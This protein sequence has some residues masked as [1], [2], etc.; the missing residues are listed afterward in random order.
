MPKGK[1]QLTVWV[2][3]DEPNP[4]KVVCAQ[5]TSKKMVGFFFEKTGH[6]VTVPLDY[7][8]TVNSEWYTTICFPEIFGVI[9]KTNK[10]HWIVLHHGN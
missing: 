4:T 6:I 1:Q 7:H 10:R 8:G 3:Q 9:R 2:L 5:S